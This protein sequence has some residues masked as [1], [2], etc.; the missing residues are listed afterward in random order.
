MSQASIPRGPSP[1]HRPDDPGKQLRQLASEL[2]DH[3]ESVVKL[4]NVARIVA[5]TLPCIAL[6]TSNN[7]ALVIGGFVIL[8]II[9]SLFG[10][11][12]KH[13]AELLHV[14]P[15]RG[16]LAP[17]TISAYASFLL[18]AFISP[19]MSPVLRTLLDCSVILVVILALDVRLAA[20]CCERYPRES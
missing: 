10:Q 2:Y 6:A 1:S 7:F 14:T 3:A 4:L 16:F 18:T 15:K 13:L 17:L 20:K 8:C 12:F 11:E 9:D 5:F 19:V